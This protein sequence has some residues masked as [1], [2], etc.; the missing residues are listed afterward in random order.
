M[1]KSTREEGRIKFA[2]HTLVFQTERGPQFI[3]ITEHVTELLA[4]S[5]LENGFIVVFSRHTTAAITINENEPHLIADMEKMLEAAAPCAADYAHNVH[6]HPIDSGDL[7]NGHSHC[8]HLLLGVSESIPVAEGRMLFGQ[9]Q[10][11]FLVELDHAREREVVVH[12]VG[13]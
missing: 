10:R 8:Q 11:I 5:G 6:G 2:S 13:E 3:D 7:P 4:Q 9:W 1:L 12:L